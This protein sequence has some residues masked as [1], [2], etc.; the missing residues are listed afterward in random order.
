MFDRPFEVHSRDDKREQKLIVPND[1]TGQKCHRV[2]KNGAGRVSREYSEA[3]I[4][5]VSSLGT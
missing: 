1:T 4:G 2:D 5:S 3:M